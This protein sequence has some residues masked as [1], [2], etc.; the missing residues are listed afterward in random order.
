MDANSELLSQEC[1]ADRWLTDSGLCSTLSFPEN[2]SASDV[3]DAL[4]LRAE[5][6]YRE[7]WH[8]CSTLEK[9]I[10]RQMAEEGV[11][12]LRNR[13][14]LSELIRKGLVVADQQNP[15]PRL[16]NHSFRKFVLNEDMP[17]GAKNLEELRGE[18]WDVL[19]NFIWPALFVGGLFLIVT[20]RKYFNDMLPLVSAIATEILALFKMFRS[21]RS[22]WTGGKVAE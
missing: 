7:L 11:V 6:H 16:M 15:K 3:L 20:Q 9:L 22:L 14:L 4:R 13:E 2:A 5:A 10:L 18:S 8:A 19:H 1:K 21:F 17:A 12:N